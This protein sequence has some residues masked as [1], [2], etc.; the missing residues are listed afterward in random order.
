MRA[1]R[2]SSTRPSARAWF[3]MFA[4]KIRTFRPAA[5]SSATATASLMSPEMK[6]I[7]GS[8]S[9]SG[10]SWVRTNY[11]PLHRPPKGALVSWRVDRRPTS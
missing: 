6:L 9:S 1:I 5:A 7:E 3:A 11:G 8:S 10:G 4:P 2:M